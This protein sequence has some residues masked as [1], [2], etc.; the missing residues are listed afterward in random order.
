MRAQPVKSP[1][2]PTLG[3]R[4][5]PPPDRGSSEVLFG[6]RLATGAR[7]VPG[8]VES[9]KSYTQKLELRNGRFV[10]GGET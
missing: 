8:K 2:S 3:K 5:A 10:R 4:L 7:P 9:R 1:Y 6:F